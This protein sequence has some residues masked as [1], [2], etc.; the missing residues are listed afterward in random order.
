VTVIL[1]MDGSC[2]EDIIMNRW[3]SRSADEFLADLELTMSQVHDM[4]AARLPEMTTTYLI[5]LQMAVEA[6]GIAIKEQ[7]WV[8]EGRVE[9]LGE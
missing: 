3:N 9:F 1:A 2:E 6:L 8:R 5:Q 4:L 7:R